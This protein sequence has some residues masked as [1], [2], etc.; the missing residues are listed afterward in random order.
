M[1]TKN[2]ND[3]VHPEYWE[4]D[5]NI[6]KKIKEDPEFQP[7]FLTLNPHLRIKINKGL[8]VYSTENQ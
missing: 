3:C 5:K 2:Y 4:E 8:Y 7:N 6:L 1:Y